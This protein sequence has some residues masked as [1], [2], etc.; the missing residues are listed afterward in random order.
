MEDF[1]LGLSAT[2]AGMSTDEYCATNDNL[3]NNLEK[4]E[5]A[6]KGA[7]VCKLDDFKEWFVAKKML[8]SLFC[9]TA[10]TNHADFE[11]VSAAESVL[12]G[13]LDKFAKNYGKASPEIRP[14]IKYVLKRSRWYYTFEDSVKIVSTLLDNGHLWQSKGWFFCTGLHLAV[15]DNVFG[16]S[17]ST[18]RQYRRYVGVCVP[19]A[20]YVEGRWPETIRAL[21]EAGMI[22]KIPLLDET[23]WEKTSI[24]DRKGCAK[25]SLSRKE[26]NFI[27]NNYLKK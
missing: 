23:L 27:R 1:V 24:D 10:N 7:K 18:G 22:S 12:G 25:I 13:K 4:I 16:I 6:V 26:R 9:Y 14:V 15:G 20:F 2:L 3:L 8:S 11:R 5:T 19:Q 21:V 17:N